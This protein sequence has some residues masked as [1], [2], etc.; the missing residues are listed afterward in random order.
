MEFDFTRI[1]ARAALQAPVQLR[2]PRPI[3]LVTTLGLDGVPNAA[4]MSFFNVFAQTPPLLILG[5]QDRAP[6]PRTPPATS[7]TPAS[8]W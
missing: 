4:P 2:R 7:A 3:A 8:S 5:L 1:G 6:A